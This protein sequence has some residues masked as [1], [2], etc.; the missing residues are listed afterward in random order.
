MDQEADTIGYDAVADFAL[1]IAEA[2]GVLDAIAHEARSE[3]P[4]ELEDLRGIIAEG[5]DSVCAIP[6]AA[7]SAGSAV[8]LPEI[9]RTMLADVMELGEAIVAGRTE[10]PAQQ[11]STIESMARALSAALDRMDDPVFVVTKARVISACA[12]SLGVGPARR[13]PGDAVETLVVATTRAA[14]GLHRLSRAADSAPR[15]VAI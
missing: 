2:T 1:L 3:R 5:L 10:V 4:A 11:T 9:L 12:D 13:H 8:T 7:T 14:S 15:Q 6:E